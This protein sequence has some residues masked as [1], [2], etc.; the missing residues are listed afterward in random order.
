MIKL[1]IVLAFCLKLYAADQ[2]V[3]VEPAEIFSSKVKTIEERLFE[4]PSSIKDFFDTGYPMSY[5]VFDSILKKHNV[6]KIVFQLTIPR[7]GTN[8]F[9]SIIKQ[10]KGFNNSYESF[11][12]INRKDSYSEIMENCNFDFSL[13]WDQYIKSNSDKGIIFF[14]SH[15]TQLHILAEFFSGECF[16]DERWLAIYQTRHN[17]V[18]QNLSL[19]NIHFGIWH[20]WEQL[21]VQQCPEFVDIAACK[22]DHS[23][24][25]HEEYDVKIHLSTLSKIF[26]NFQKSSFLTFSYEDLVA[27]TFCVIRIVLEEAGRSDI[28]DEEIDNAIKQSLVRNNPEGRNAQ[29]TTL[30]REKDI[31][32]SL[33]LRWKN[34][35]HAHAY[36]TFTESSLSSS[37][38][39]EEKDEVLDP[40]VSASA[41]EGIKEDEG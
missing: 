4:N 1:C 11:L 25:I 41:V 30:L 15:F 12:L 31:R 17:F 18:M 37:G 24:N 38:A 2:Q 8:F 32:D 35:M 19:F 40:S 13:F 29:I 33:K 22:N 23:R 14:F 3:F 28:T 36:P 20:N 27:D 9:Q 10:F 26:S 39:I 6:H 5:E 7:S 34:L 16:N 21:E